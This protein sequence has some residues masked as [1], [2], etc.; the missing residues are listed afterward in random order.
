MRLYAFL[1]FLHVLGVVIWVGG[2]FMMHFAVRPSAVELLPPPQRVP[3][4]AAT[5]RRFFGWVTIAV[6][7]V[8]ASGLLMFFGIGMAAGA[9]A[10]GK[11][12]FLEGIRLAHV[13]VH[14]MFIIGLVMMAIYAHIRLAPFKR[15]HAAVTAQDWA[16]GARHLDQVRQLVAI[17]LALGV[18]V[19]GVATLGRAIL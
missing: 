19:I 6:L 14:A 12:A 10:A 13:S 2:M 16:A 1:L 8:L 3:L 7:V 11:N 9:M 17:N 18:I 15:L 5:L 4:L